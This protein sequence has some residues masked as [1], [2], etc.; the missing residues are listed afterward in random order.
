M[1]GRMKNRKRK[2]LK[3]ISWEAASNAVCFVLA[4]FVFGNIGECLVFT[5]ACVAIK[6]VMYYYHECLWGE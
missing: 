2:L 4:Y 5:V 3:A 6:L 1:D